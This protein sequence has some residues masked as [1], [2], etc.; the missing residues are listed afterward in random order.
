MQRIMGGMKNRPA[1]K[2]DWVD[3][4]KVSY[5]KVDANAITDLLIREIGE[6]KSMVQDNCS[7]KMM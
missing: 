1:Y 4:N 6:T 5:A 2:K 3:L 7:T